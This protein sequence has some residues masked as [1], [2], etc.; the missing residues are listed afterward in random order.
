[1]WNESQL[2]QKEKALLKTV[3]AVAGGAGGRP[4]RL[5]DN[6]FEIG[7]NSL[8][9]VAVVTKLRDQG[10]NL[11][12]STYQSHL[13]F[14]SEQFLKMLLFILKSDMSTFLSANC[15]EELIPKLDTCCISSVAQ[16]EIPARQYSL[17]MLTPSTKD[18][19]IRYC[20][21]LYAILF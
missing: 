18:D 11:G 12:S 3:L 16:E 8:N 19:V 14:V 6:F 15:L 4:I 21:Y 20:H 5:T 1:M 7:G 10:F 2:N 17:E 9:A 13:Q